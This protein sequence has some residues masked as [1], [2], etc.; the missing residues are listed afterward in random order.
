MLKNNIHILYGVLYIYLFVNKIY[1]YINIWG[2]PWWLSSKDSTCQC[3]RLKFDSWV[4]KIPQKRKWQPTPVF[5]P[6]KSHGKKSLVDY[7][8]HR[9]PR[10]RHDLVTKPLPHKHTCMRVSIHTHTH[11]HT[12]THNSRSSGSIQP[13]LTFI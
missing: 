6:G 4:G 13:L 7:T 2:L 3:R 9:V 10:G 11:T 1:V 12:H 5:L 8:V